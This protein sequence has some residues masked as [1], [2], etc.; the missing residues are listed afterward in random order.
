VIVFPNT[1]FFRNAVALVTASSL[2]VLITLATM[3]YFVLIPVGK[4]SANDLAAL[5]VFSAQTWVELPPETR[6]DLEHE[7]LESHGLKLDTS[8]SLK[9][10]LRPSR[11]YM[12]ILGK[13][14]EKRMGYPA[15]IGYLV[16]HDGWYWADITIADQTLRFGFT[17]DRIGARPPMALFTISM[18]ILLVA[19]ATALILALRLSRPLAVLSK[20][21]VAIGRGEKQLIL[22]QGGPDEVVVLAN[23]F[24]QLSH[25]IEA[26]LE[27]RTTL[28][29]GLSHDL[30]TPLTR[31]HLALE[32]LPEIRQS[33]VGTDVYAGLDEMEHLIQEMLLLARGVEVQEKSEEVDLNEVITSV[34]VSRR[35]EGMEVRWKQVAKLPWTVPVHRLKRVLGNLLENAIRYGNGKPVEVEMLIEAGVPVIKVLDRGPG[36]PQELRHRVF[37]P[38]YRVDESRSTATGGSGLGLAIVQQLCSTLGWRVS[39]HSRTGGGI[40][41]SLKLEENLPGRSG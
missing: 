33:D 11:P 10:L 30:R 28:L 4:Q 40:E 31:I 37:R 21:T 41:V 36:I 27:N 1:I 13:A 7:L 23:N 20:A 25:E 32:F 16:E 35:Q 26:L 22:P 9:P 15:G 12:G 3:A 2:L 29:A 5:L 6:A 24:N 14:L 38:F 19:I 8:S 18:A 39:I 34:V 17:A